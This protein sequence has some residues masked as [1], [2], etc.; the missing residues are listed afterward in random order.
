MKKL[1]LAAA[2]AIGGVAAPQVSNVAHALPVCYNPVYSGTV[3]G[4]SGYYIFIGRS[5]CANWLFVGPKSRDCQVY[6]YF[7][8]SYCPSQGGGGGGSW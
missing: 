3:Y 1:L 8:G 4:V 7:N 6:E 2:I 5:G